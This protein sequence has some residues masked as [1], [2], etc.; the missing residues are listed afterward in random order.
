MIRQ[1]ANYNHICDPHHLQPC[2]DNNLSCK[3]Q[4]WTNNFV[5][6]DKAQ[7]RSFCNNDEECSEI[8]HAKCSADKQCICRANNI[9]I[10]DTYCS[11]KLGAFCWND[12][13]CSTENSI[14]IEKSCKCKEN[15]QQSKQQCVPLIIGSPCENNASCEEVKFSKCSDFQIC[16]CLVNTMP[17]N[18]TLCLPLLNAPCQTNDDCYVDD[19]I[20]INSACQCRFRPLTESSN[21]CELAHLG[22]SCMS[23]FTCSRLLNHSICS[24]SGKCTCDTNLYLIENN[25]CVPLVDSVC[26]D[27]EQ[28]ATKNAICIENKCQCEPNYIHQELNCNPIYLNGTCETHSD[29]NTIRF[30]MCSENNKCVCRNKYISIDPFTCTASLGASCNDIKE[31]EPADLICITGQCQHNANSSILSNNKPLHD[32]SVNLR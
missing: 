1:C 3:P 11:P 21:K 12:E 6:R 24:R 9:R 16:V 13:K 5:C 19:S 26:W 22:M 17:V 29:C 25:K 20:C 27:N 23:N 10:N 31:C 8:L 4:Q 28:C 2:C 7:L 18:R 15:Y 32:K 14:C 30:S